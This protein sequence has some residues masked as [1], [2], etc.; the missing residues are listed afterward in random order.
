[1]VLP[2]PWAYSHET[3]AELLGLPIPR[4]WQP[5]VALD[6]VR[7]TQSAPVRRSGLRGRRGLESRAVLHLHGVPVTDPVDT[8]C[9]LAT[10]LGL[11]DLVVAGDA[12]MN[13]LAG[14]S[15]V[16]ADAVTDR[17]GHRGARVLAQA[18]PLLRVGSGSPMETRA[19]LA[20]RD[21]GLPEPELN[22]DI[23]DEHGDWVARAD[24]VWRAARL[25]VEYEG[26]IHRTDRRQWLMD[27][28][29]TQLLEDLGW[30]VLRITARDLSTPELA[31]AMARRICRALVVRMPEHR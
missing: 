26:D 3:A 21:G 11:T 12:V 24:F 9:D 8:W 14:T 15:A 25:V 2:V 13:R 31:R 30:R 28:A 4:S 1:M 17:R 19:R 23:L 6:V 20:F 5:G 7:P 18:L 29:R 27:V 10:C 22:A 16:L